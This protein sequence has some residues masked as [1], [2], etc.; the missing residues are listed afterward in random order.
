MTK[1]LSEDEVMLVSRMKL[2][3]DTASTFK[4]VQH[5]TNLNLDGK[6]I[7]MIH[8]IEFHEFNFH[9][10]IEVGLNSVEQVSFQ[11][12]RESQTA[13]LFPSDDDV[14]QTH[15]HSLSRSPAIGTDAGPLSFEHT[16]PFCYDFRVPLPYAR[17]NIFGAIIGTDAAQLAEGDIRIFYTIREVDDKTFFR[18]AQNC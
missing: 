18:I 8:K 15:T 13:L 6:H 16:S 4:Q 5:A 2:K 14:I 7:W 12:T 9:N 17:A 1:K 10:A 3:E 11:L